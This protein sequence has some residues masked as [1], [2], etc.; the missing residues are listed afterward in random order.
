MKTI[1]NPTD[2]VQFSFKEH[3][4]MQLMRQENGQAM[5]EYVIVAAA[6]VIGVL[7]FNEL[8]I[9]RIVFLYRFIGCMVSLPF[10]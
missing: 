7:A 1:R 5:V 6:V 10:P 3:V 2:T 4:S 9:P 8:V